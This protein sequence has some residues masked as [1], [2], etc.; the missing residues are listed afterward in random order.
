MK[1]LQGHSEK[2]TDFLNDQENYAYWPLD[3]LSRH[4]E[5]GLQHEIISSARA[6][7]GDLRK[8]FGGTFSHSVDLQELCD[9]FDD[10]WYLMVLDFTRD[11]KTVY[12]YI[13]ELV[14]SHHQRFVLASPEFSSISCIY[15]QSGV[16]GHQR[17]KDLAGFLN[18][19]VDM[20]ESLGAREQFEEVTRQSRRFCLLYQRLQFLKNEVLLKRAIEMENVVNRPPVLQ[21]KEITQKTNER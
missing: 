17:S 7:S 3:V 20:G 5:S 16:S 4:L 8:L 13:Q 6:I 10:I 9:E 14:S 1:E 11:S 19:L 12:P 2:K 18:R 21:G 15:D